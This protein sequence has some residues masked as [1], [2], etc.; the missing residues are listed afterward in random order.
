MSDQLQQS[1]ME[2]KR[3]NNLLDIG[4]DISKMGGWEYHLQSR[5]LFVTK[6]INDIKDLDHQVVLDYK[7][8]LD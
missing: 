8:I 5:E 4:L 1:T 7:T 3:I 6:Q 2:L